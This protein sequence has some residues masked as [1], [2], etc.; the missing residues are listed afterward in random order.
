MTFVSTPYFESSF[1]WN[2]SNVPPALY[3]RESSISVMKVRFDGRSIVYHLFEGDHDGVKCYFFVH[4]SSL[5]HFPT[6]PPSLV[7]FS[8]VIVSC[9][10]LKVKKDRYGASG[11]FLE[12]FRNT[13]M[14]HEVHAL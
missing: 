13:I 12:T 7:D 4:H 10:D 6:T 3:T 2:L 9:A 5:D 8:D 11:V 14:V 1:V